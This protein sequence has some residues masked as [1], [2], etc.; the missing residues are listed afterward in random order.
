MSRTGLLRHR[1]ALPRSSTAIGAIR[2]TFA[3][4]SS[5]QASNASPIQR[6]APA[7]NVASD[8][9]RVSGWATGCS[10]ASASDCSLSAPA[11]HG[12]APGVAACGRTSESALWWPT[13]RDH[14]GYGVL[15]GRRA[16]PPYEIGAKRGFGRHRLTV[17]GAML[18]RHVDSSVERRAAQHRLIARFRALE[19]VPR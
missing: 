17:A 10:V 18:R 8:A 5:V 15:S 12:A 14:G 1:V 2:P 4:S 3:W 6:F 7:I 13:C 19:L 9:V 11:C 16:L